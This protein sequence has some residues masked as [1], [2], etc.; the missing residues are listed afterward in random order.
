MLTGD[1]SNSDMWKG[2]LE[3]RKFELLREVEYEMSFRDSE[4]VNSP[5]EADRAEKQETA[6]D[7]PSRGSS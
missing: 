6:R 3:D 7:L 2:L 4:L 5:G 1:E